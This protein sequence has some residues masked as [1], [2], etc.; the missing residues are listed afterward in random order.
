MADI[1]GLQEAAGSRFSQFELIGRGSLGDVHKAFDKEIN[2]EVAIKVID[3]EESEDE[4]DDIQK[5]IAVL[6]QCHSPYITEYYGSYINQTKL[7]I[8]MEYMAGGSVA[9][10]L[11]SGLPLDETSIA[12][13]AQDL[14]HAIE[15][16]H[17]EGKIHR[18]IKAA[19]ILLTENGD[20]KVVPSHKWVILGLNY[21]NSLATKTCIFYGS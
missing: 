8:I 11:Q 14:L 15:Y 9:D 6:S 13:I 17:T 20:V 2:K 3:L 4:I 10:L 12:W 21:L 19:N 7:W 5:E 18:D 1:A 16:L